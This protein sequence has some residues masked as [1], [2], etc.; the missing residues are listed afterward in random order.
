MIYTMMSPLR[1]DNITA[2]PQMIHHSPTD[3]GLTG[4]AV[5]DMA[6]I[7]I[8]VE[9]AGTGIMIHHRRPEGQNE[10]TQISAGKTLAQLPAGYVSHRSA[11]GIW[12]H[13]D[14]QFAP[15]RVSTTKS[16]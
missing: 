5:T 8:V 11:D 6:G 4:T 9:E 10:E 15:C 13:M 1:V 7:V 16:G 12:S 3:M 14:S 2:I